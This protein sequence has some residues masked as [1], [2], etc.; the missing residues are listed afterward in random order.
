MGIEMSGPLCM[1]CFTHRPISTQALKKQ[2]ASLAI[3]IN[4]RI[5]LQ[6]YSLSLSLVE[7]ALAHPVRYLQ[8]HRQICLQKAILCHGKFATTQKQ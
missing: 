8:I 2:A 3:G 1:Q 7:R 5:N 6:Y 4:Y